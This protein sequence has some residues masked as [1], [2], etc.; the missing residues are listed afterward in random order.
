V[1]PTAP[2]VPSP[3]RQAWKQGDSPPQ[4]PTRPTRAA[5]YMTGLIKEVTP[6]RKPDVSNPYQTANPVKMPAR[7]PATRRFRPP[8][9][10][11]E[12]QQKEPEMTAQ[13]IIEATVP[14]VSSQ[15]LLNCGQ[16][17][18]DS[19]EVSVQ[20]L[21]QRWRRQRNQLAKSGTQVP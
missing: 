14:K 8:A 1:K 6:P 2:A 12:K 15:S 16:A 21:R 7:K 19:R 9:E 10:N 4:P 5:N 11:K 17:N 20:G 3:L 13:A 18:V